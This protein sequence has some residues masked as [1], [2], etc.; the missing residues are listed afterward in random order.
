[1]PSIIY[2]LKNNRLKI[3]LT[4]ESVS[5]GFP[6]PAAD[7]IEDRI[8]FNELLVKNPSATFLVKVS[9][10]SMIDSFIP[11]KALLV[12]DRSLTAANNTIV[13]AVVNGEFLVKKLQKANG[14]IFLLP[15]NKNLN[16]IEITD[17]MDF[18]VWGVVSKII[19]DPKDI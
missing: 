3:P 16:P 2:T 5:A 14:K 11:P 1:M 19:I 17:T 4:A 8:D 18:Q 15:A 6:S 12:V 13:V 9:G 7:Y 10:E